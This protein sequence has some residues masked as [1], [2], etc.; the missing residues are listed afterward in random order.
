MKASVFASLALAGAFSLG[1]GCSSSSDT[2]GGAT[3]SGSQQTDSGTGSDTGGGGDTG[4]GV[5]LNCD[6]YCAKNISVCS[7]DHSQ[8][9]DAATCK[10]MCAKFTTGKG[11]DTTGDTLGCRAYHTG[12][13]GGLNAGTTTPDP[14]THCTHSGPFGGNTCGDSRCADWCVLAL[15]QCTGVTGVPFT[16]TTSCMSI[17]GAA[18]SLDTTIPEL[19]PSAV[20]KMNCLE[21]HLEAAYTDPNLHCPHLTT[22]SG[23]CKP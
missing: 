11:T 1:M 3:D 17:C 20:G 10:A 12:A 9:I 7:G 14:N 5:A 4:V 15:A 13:A 6:D 18:S 16:D 22:A 21:Y 23:P 8:Y 19:G 2:S